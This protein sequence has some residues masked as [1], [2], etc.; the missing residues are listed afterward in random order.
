MAA[1]TSESEWREMTH[2]V[3][4]ATAGGE[5]I[6]DDLASAPIS[7]IVQDGGST[8][9]SGMV[10]AELRRVFCAAAK[11]VHLP[12]KAQTSFCNE[13]HIDVAGPIMPV[14]LPVVVDDTR[15]MRLGRRQLRT[16]WGNVGDL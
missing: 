11:S 13:S 10:I 4:P 3:L 6:P 9:T 15:R 16:R 14:K 7:L 12:H 8:G 1:W 2:N 5:T